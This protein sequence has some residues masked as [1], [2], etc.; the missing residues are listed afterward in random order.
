[1]AFAKVSQFLFSLNIFKSSSWNNLFAGLSGFIGR[2][3]YR[4]IFLPL[5]R[6]ADICQLIFKK[7]AGISSNGVRFQ[8]L[9]TSNGSDIV[10]GDI[11][12]YIVQSDAVKNIL[13]AMLA[14]AV[15]LLL[16]SVFVATIKTEF[17]KDGN[18][19]K[20]KVIKFAF[21]GM[22]NFVL[23]PVICLFGLFM[24]NVILRAIDG[25]TNPTGSQTTLS[26][27]I[28]LAGGYN[29]NRTRQSEIKDEGSDSID[30][31]E[32]KDG[33]KSFGKALQTSD[34][35]FGIFLDDT[36]GLVRRTAADKIDQAF[37]TQY[38]AKI[39]KKIT[40]DLSELGMW[41]DGALGT[42][43]GLH[44]TA[45]TGFD[46]L[47][48]SKD[49][50]LTIPSG[51]QVA[52]SIYDVGL[53]YTYY[54]L[55]IGSFDYLISFVCLVFCAYTLLIA[56]LGLVKRMFYLSILFIISPGVCAIYPVDEGKA[57]ERWRTDFIKYTLS[58]YSVVIVLNLFLALLPT[59]LRLE[60]FTSWRADFYPLPIP[61]ELA[62]YL[63]R[64]LIVIGGLTFFKDAT[65]Q[66]AA[67]IGAADANSEGADAAGKFAKNV[68][69]TAKIA[70]VAGALTGKAVKA[71]A[72][73]ANNTLNAAYQGAVNA[74]TGKKQKDTDNVA[75]DDAQKQ[76]NIDAQAKSTNNGTNS[77]NSMN[78]G[79]G[80]AGPTTGPE[81]NDAN[82]TADNKRPGYTGNLLKDMGHGI[83][84]GGAAI[85]KKIANTK[86]GQKV[87][88]GAGKVADLAKA[89]KDKVADVY[90][91]AGKTVPGKIFKGALGAVGGVTKSILTP[92]G[93]EVKALIKHPIKHL[94]LRGTEAVNVAR[95]VGDVVSG[96][97]KND[98]KMKDV[99]K[100][101]GSFKGGSRYQREEAKKAMEKI[102][103]EKEKK[104]VEKMRSE[105]SEIANKIDKISDEQGK[106]NRQVN[107]IDKKTD[108]INKKK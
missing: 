4:L 49:G 80:S 97:V 107:D 10:T 56:A 37:A 32:D 81:S 43:I 35:N 57:L 78:T 68:S 22:A 12:Q 67:I 25:A 64:L 13:W 58:A 34:A 39:D 89:G 24:G 55:R 38:T 66:I 47:R 30:Y 61:L 21:R 65:K 82:K 6:I 17:A 93:K 83:L 105:I 70:G 75:K 104:S 60:L 52:F 99:K 26:A 50:K 103:G 108:N 76:Q 62:N 28:F 87:A 100:W 96:L 1:M 86:L 73:F 79:T 20:R 63:A 31:Y 74:V 102:E 41:Y 45:A 90:K 77:N 8:G 14:L 54:D 92:I 5:C 18:N 88:R 84:A 46:T 69:R 51:K 33:T 59:L 98:I 95:G 85:G 15:V 40:I 11:V 9:N 44:L 94:K 16:I 101:T 19:N 7:L 27:Q 23:V 42:D 36:S 71:G 72:H 106:I 48:I 3:L 53:V 91:N 29:A 2:L